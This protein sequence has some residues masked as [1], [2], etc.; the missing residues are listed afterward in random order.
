MK[1]GGGSMVVHRVVLPPHG[2]SVLPMFSWGSS[3]FPNTKYIS[4]GGLVTPLFL[5]GMNVSMYMAPSNR[6]VSHSGCFSYFMPSVL[7]Y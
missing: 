1:R 7:S 6:V 4:V 5:L 3:H 2:A